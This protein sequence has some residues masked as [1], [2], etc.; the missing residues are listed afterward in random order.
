MHWLGEGL[1]YATFDQV[2]AEVEQMADLLLSRQRRADKRR[3]RN[4]RRARRRD[5]LKG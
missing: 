5:N 3:R 1:S 2:K 4:E